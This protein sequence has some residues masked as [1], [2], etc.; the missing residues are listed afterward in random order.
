M[1]IK[2]A[3]ALR[4]ADTS[5]TVSLV[6]IALILLVGDKVFVPPGETQNS[7]VELLKCIAAVISLQS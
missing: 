3:G 4:C 6:D 2:D 7:P 5:F 1:A